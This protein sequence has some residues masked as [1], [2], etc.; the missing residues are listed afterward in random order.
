VIELPLLLL[1]GA[2]AGCLGALLGIGGGV[3]LV[4]LLNAGF[5][6]S[7]QQAAAVSLVGVLATAGSVAIS[8]K[9]RELLNVRLAIVL[10]IFSVSGALA[11]ASLL[12]VLSDAAY[13]RIFAVTTVTIAALM[14]ARLDKRNVLP[15][16]VDTG[17]LGGRFHDDDTKTTV[18]YRIKRLPVATA[19]ATTAGALATLIGIGGGIVVVPAL[20]SLCGVPMRAAA[21]TSAFMIGVTAVPGS[22]A[23]WNQG[24][25]GDFHVAAGIALGVFGGYQI[26][27]W[28]GTRAAVR[29]LKILMSIILLAV[30]ARYLLP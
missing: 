21:A 24:H 2:V 23:R 15:A 14:L 25:L 17:T 9:T 27:V 16:D 19:V 8:S 1:A 4:P 29:A 12:T 10:L 30:A 18:A 11:G 26:G 13:K 6:L 5:G 7:F 3:V 20:N 22:I 28:L